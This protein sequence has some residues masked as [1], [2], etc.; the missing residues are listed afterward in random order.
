VRYPYPRGVGVPRLD[1]PCHLHAPSFASWGPATDIAGERRSLFDGR[2]FSR[3]ILTQRGFPPL[4]PEGGSGF[5]EARLTL[6][7][8]AVDLALTVGQLVRPGLQN[9]GDDERPFPGRRELVSPRASCH[10]RSTKSPTWRS[11][12]RTLGRGSVAG[13]ADT[14]PSVARPCPEPPPAGPV[15]LLD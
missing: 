4:A 3:K 6:P 2:L 7:S 9:L 12:D 14:A 5:A 13:T 1:R 8:V 15:S 10:N 11:R